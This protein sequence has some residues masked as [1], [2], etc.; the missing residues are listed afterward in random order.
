MSNVTTLHKCNRCSNEWESDVNETP[1]TCPSCH[2]GLWADL[3]GK[4]FPW[5]PHPDMLLIGDPSRLVIVTRD[6]FDPKAKPV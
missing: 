3:S 4:T 1:V 2:S 5:E 6:P